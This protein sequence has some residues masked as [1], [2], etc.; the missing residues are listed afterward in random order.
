MSI[1]PVSVN[2]LEKAPGFNR[3]IMVAS[4]GP[5]SASLAFPRINPAARPGERVPSS[6][7]QGPQGEEPGVSVRPSGGGGVSYTGVASQFSGQF[8]GQGDKAPSEGGKAVGA[9]EKELSEEEKKQVSDLRKRDAEVRAHE[10]A[11]ASAGGGHAG[12]PSYEMQRGPDGKSYA[13]GGEVAIDT[14][15]ESTPQATVRKMDTVIRAALAPADPSPQDQK[16]AAAARQTRIAAQVEARKL[17]EAEQAGGDED[18]G[19]PQ[20]ADGLERTGGP[21]QA[22]AVGEAETA[23]GIAQLAVSEDTAATADDRGSGI[24]SE[25]SYA[26]NANYA[27]GEPAEAAKPVGRGLFGNVAGAAGGGAPIFAGSGQLLGFNEADEDATG[28]SRSQG[29]TAASGVDADIR[30]AASRAYR[31]KDTSAVF[32]AL[33]RL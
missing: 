15:A 23:Q 19:R 12:S 30:L 27:D 8:A 31:A 33:S 10:N 7:E 6:G 2:G 20:D 4:I 9:G 17:R 25:A 21:Q 24:S 13:V 22:D 14:S 16:V 18:A 5:F 32:N 1:Q 3:G 11:H 26:A 29:S 28:A